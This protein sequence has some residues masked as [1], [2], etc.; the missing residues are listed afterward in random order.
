[1]DF[2]FYIAQTPT[3]ADKATDFLI[4]IAKV[5]GYIIGA[6]FIV[7]T[8]YAGFLL[9]TSGGKDDNMTKVKNI[10]LTIVLSSLVIF[11]FILITY[12]IFAEFT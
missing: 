3:L 4:N 8:F 11:L 1:M 2:V 7:F 5:L 6:L 10:L 12:Q 9:L